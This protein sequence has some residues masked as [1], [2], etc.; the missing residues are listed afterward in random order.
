MNEIQNRPVGKCQMCGQ[1]IWE[2]ARY[3]TPDY[4]PPNLCDDCGCT[5]VR[6]EPEEQHAFLL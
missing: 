6:Y 1:M 4:V 2:L 3:I 5:G